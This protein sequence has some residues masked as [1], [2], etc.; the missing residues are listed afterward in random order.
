MTSPSHGEAPTPEV[1]AYLAQKEVSERS[2]FHIAVIAIAVLGAGFLLSIGVI[3]Y[4][5]TTVADI[6]ATVNSHTTQL[7][8]QSKGYD[9]VLKD[10]RLAF[11]G[12]KN[13]EDYAQAPKGC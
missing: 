4:V 3:L 7:T 9:A 2:A 13:A 8:C 5:A 10:A 6:K 11:M 1:A 12:D